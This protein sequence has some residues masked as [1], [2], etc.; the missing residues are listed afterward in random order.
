MGNGRN[1]PSR[2]LLWRRELTEPHWVLQ[3]ARWVL[4]KT[5]WVLFGT[6]IIG[7][8]ELT[9]FAPRNSVSPKP[10]G[11]GERKNSFSLEGMKKESIPTHETFIL[12]WNFHSRF[13][14]FILDWK[15]Q[16][17]ALFFCGQGGAWNE[18]THSRLKMSFRIE[19]LIFPIVP[20]EIEFFQS[21]GP[22][23]KNSL[24]SVFETV[25]PETVF[26]RMAKGGGTK[27]GI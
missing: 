2:V 11:P 13:E 18:K 1:T 7:W 24:S 5:R 27:G 22:L 9:E 26:W 12:A 6:Q 8:E 14:K 4:R 25:L 23:G 17:Q 3:Q 21:W 16:S 15:L 20:L 10:R 19:S